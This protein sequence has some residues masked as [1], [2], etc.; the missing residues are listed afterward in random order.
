MITQDR[1]LLARISEIVGIA[2]IFLLLSSL[3]HAATTSST[4]P[5]YGMNSY[6]MRAV[7]SMP[8]GG[9]YS[10]GSL[11]FERLSK[12]AVIWD[13][14]TSKLIIRPDRARPS[15]CSAACYL[16][17]LQAIK[18]WENASPQQ[19][20][21]SSC[22]QQFAISTPQADGVGAW[23]RVNSNGPGLSKWIHD[24]GAGVNFSNP[25]LARQGDFLKIFWT[26]EIGAKEFGHLVVFIA[27]GRSPK[28]GTLCVRFWSA[29]QNMGYGIKT[30][31][32]ES[33]KRM[34]F[35]RITRPSAFRKM[36]QLPLNDEWLG[37]LLRERVSDDE[38]RRRCGIL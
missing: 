28:D 20:L 27:Y 22:W 19:V 3:S 34:I 12:E 36:G 5:S 8:Q 24:L 13:T 14:T 4:L 25:L 30:V 37:S 38:V 9:G 17:L 33:I 16:V 35:T 31:P 11:A 26:D 18:L 10:T 32:V 21:P 6:V 1:R 23:G 2:L 7:K 15:F 29:N